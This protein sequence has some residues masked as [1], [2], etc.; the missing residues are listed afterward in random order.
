MKIEKEQ[1]LSEVFIK[2][3]FQKL[4]ATRVEY[5]KIDTPRIDIRI[6]Q[7]KE[8]EDGNKTYFFTTKGFRVKEEVFKQLLSE[9]K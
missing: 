6:M 7:L 3:N 5:E 2:G 8:Q 9:F 4:R 1:I